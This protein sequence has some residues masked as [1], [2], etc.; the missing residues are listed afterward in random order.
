MNVIARHSSI[1]GMKGINDGH[2]INGN[3]DINNHRC[4]YCHCH[5]FV[6]NTTRLIQPQ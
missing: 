6:S 4:R 1:S 2:D 3:D 5:H